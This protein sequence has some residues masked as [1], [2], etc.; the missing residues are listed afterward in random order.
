[1][2]DTALVGMGLRAANPSRPDGRRMPGAGIKH[3]AV[4]ILKSDVAL[5][6]VEHN[7]AI[8]AT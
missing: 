4:S 2:V 5:G 7:R 1:M 8:Q 3:Q 6:R